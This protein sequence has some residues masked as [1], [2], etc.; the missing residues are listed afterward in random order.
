MAFNTA[1]ALINPLFKATDQAGVEVII[2]L[3]VAAETTEGIINN[4]AYRLRP[5]LVIDSRNKEHAS[6][7]N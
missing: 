4:N 2:N 5:G 3:M 7:F 1:N 6:L